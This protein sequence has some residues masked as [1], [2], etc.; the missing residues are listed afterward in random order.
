MIYGNLNSGL[1]EH[2]GEGGTPADTLG[3]QVRPVTDRHADTR[4]ISSGSNS[5]RSS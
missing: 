1:S 2:R 3:T 4:T 5:R